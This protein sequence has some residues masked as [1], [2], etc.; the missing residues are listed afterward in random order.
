[1]CLLTSLARTSQRRLP[2][3]PV[4]NELSKFLGWD[5]THKTMCEMQ[6]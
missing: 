4:L 5:T 1:M 3:K 6:S 2:E